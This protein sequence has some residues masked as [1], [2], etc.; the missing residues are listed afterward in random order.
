MSLIK[1]GQWVLRVF[2]HRVVIETPNGDVVARVGKR[3]QQRDAMAQVVQDGRL[4]SNSP[5]L[6]VTCREM[7]WSGVSYDPSGAPQDAC[8][9]CHWFKTAGHHPQCRFRPLNVVLNRIKG[10]SDKSVSGD[11]QTGP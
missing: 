10:S 1:R 11:T 2:T 3:S 4:I 5:D 7:E 9:I 8:P 6:Y